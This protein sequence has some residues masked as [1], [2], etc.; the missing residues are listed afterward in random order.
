MEWPAIYQ[1]GDVRE[2]GHH[3]LRRVYIE[4]GQ[5]E[6]HLHQD[7][8]EAG[9]PELIQQEKIGGGLHLGPGI[10]DDG[11]VRR[12]R[13]GEDGQIIPDLDV[14]PGGEHL[15]G[16]VLRPIVVGHIPE[17]AARRQ[18]QHRQQNAGGD[19][20]PFAAVFRHCLFHYVS[21]SF[22]SSVIRS[23]PVPRPS[24]PAHRLGRV[25]TAWSSRGWT[26]RS[27][28]RH[29]SD[30]ST[31]S[32]ARL[33]KAT[34]RRPWVRVTS[35]RPCPVQIVCRLLLGKSGGG[36]AVQKS[37]PEQRRQL[38]PLERRHIIADEGVPAVAVDGQEALC[39]P[40][41]R[42]HG[43]PSRTAG[44]ARCHRAAASV[45]K[46]AGVER[47]GPVPSLLPHGGW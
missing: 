29:R 35:H 31:S 24:E 17:K 20:P 26:C 12:I 45:S 4:D 21:H 37:L 27:V 28:S 18:D 41:R 7:A 22:S 47:S 3:I 30:A 15:Q 14:V 16:H 13:G 1:C 33:R 40:V 42:S 39:A 5:V 19:L 46:T 10:E 9:L 44:P 8:G 34:S 2:L 43:G 25:L 36:E 11:G 32:Q 23:S 38:R 6:G